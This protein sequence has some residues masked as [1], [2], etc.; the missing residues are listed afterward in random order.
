MP[1]APGGVCGGKTEAMLSSEPMPKRALLVFLAFFALAVTAQGAEKKELVFEAGPSQ[2]TLIQ[3]FSSDASAH[4]NPALE[5]M[6]RQADKDPEKVLWKTF[7]PVALHVSHW[8]LPEYKDTQSRAEF[9][10]MLLSYRRAWNVGNVF[11]PTVAANGI[12]WSGWSRGQSVPRAAAG[13]VG[14]LIVKPI[15]EADSNTAPTYAAEFAPEE[16]LRGGLYV[17]HT[18]LLGFGLYT[19]PAGGKN[20][21]V[22]LRHDFIVKKYKKMELKRDG[23][24]YRTWVQIVVPRASRSTVRYGLAFWVTSP[25]GPLPIQAAGGFLPS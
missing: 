3:F 15:K 5:W 14:M 8:D 7:V 10:Q 22:S 21:A 16:S 17:L 18:A 1:Y 11:P 24:V 13:R 19:K 12:E 4:C 25:D 2:N 23:N 6:S 9:D 20:R